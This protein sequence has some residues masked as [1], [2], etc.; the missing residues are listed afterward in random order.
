MAPSRRP[1]EHVLCLALRTTRRGV[2]AGPRYFTPDE[3]AEA[4]AAT[5]G[6][7][8]PTQLRAMIRPT[9][10][11][12]S[13]EFRA[14]APRDRPSRSSAGAYG[15]WPHQRCRLATVAFAAAWGLFFGRPGG[16]GVTRCAT[17]TPV[18]LYGQAVPDA[19]TCRA[20]ALP[21]SWADVQTSVTDER[22][23]MTVAISGPDS[24]A[25]SLTL[26]YLPTSACPA[27][28]L[29]ATCP[30]D[31]PGVT[32]QDAEV[33]G[34][35]AQVWGFDPGCVVLQTDRSDDGLG[36]GGRPGAAGVAGR[37]RRR[38]RAGSPAAGRRR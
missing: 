17:S 36:R 2:R 18:L 4:F 10:V 32:V 16:G 38:G 7:T 1:G 27:P 23:S 6:L 30:G 29:G 21:A 19:A 37:P 28:L 24:E 14:L 31:Q 9:A 22:L 12:S 5:K 15:A 13:A 8:V 3:L 25:G 20:S 26:R 34:R 11:T 33:S 35:P